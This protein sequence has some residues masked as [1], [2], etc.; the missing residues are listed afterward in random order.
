MKE[1]VAVIGAGMIGL[2]MCALLTGN[3]IPTYLY[4]R[5]KTEEHKAR[6]HK[7]LEELAADCYLTD[8]E[9]TICESY[10]F[11]V[12]SYEELK[13]VSVIFECAAEKLE[14]KQDIFTKLRENCPSLQVVA[15][16]TSA[17]SSAELAEA[18]GMPDKVIVAHPFY[19]PH[20]IPCVEVVPNDHTSPG[21][22]EALTKLLK[23]LNREVVILKKDAPGFV[24]N[25][26][27]YAMLREAVHIVE[28]GIAEPSDVDRILKFSFAPRYTEIGIFEHFD[29]CGLDLARDISEYLYPKLSDDKAVQ[30]Y[31]NERCEQGYYGV[32]SGRGVY[33]WD[34]KRV[35]ELHKRV[36]A[37]YDKYFCWNVPEKLYKE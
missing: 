14:V 22:L 4:V 7:I 15:S 30:K 6:Y 3:G 37:P 16:A 12:T 19:P 23:I 24:A 11:I 18:S 36:K 33:H 29:N 20:L 13:E 28:Q 32:K 27:Q 34:Q 26:L 5:G 21:S 2:S 1:K 8:K 35:E 31:I 9:I 25:R 10:L 17:I